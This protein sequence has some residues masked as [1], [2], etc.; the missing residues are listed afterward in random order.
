M[1]NSILSILFLLFSAFG[2]SQT[3]VSGAIT[4]DTVWSLTNSPYV[5][6]GN[7]VVFENYTLTVEPG[8]V[9]KFDDNVQ[10]RIQGAI[11]AKG[12][13]SKNIIFTS[14]NSNP[15]KG[16][17]NEIKIDFRGRFT[18]EYVIM[19]YANSALR[20]NHVISSSI[21]NSIFQHNNNA[22]EVNSGSPQWPVFI[23]STKFINN[24][25]GIANYHDEVNLLN[26]EF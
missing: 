21:K 5:I 15:Q 22:I 16:S 19:E 18:L 9:V 23:E 26:C 11:I 2:F 25:K 24:D 14:N 10:L 12:D 20:Y 3:T 4:S 13:S 8:V 1:K 7:T 6:T 17:W